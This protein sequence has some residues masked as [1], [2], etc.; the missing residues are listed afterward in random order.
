MLKLNS[1]TYKHLSTNR[2]ILKEIK[3]NH[4]LSLVELQLDS[5]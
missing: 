3:N 1:R 4:K 2:N 5:Y